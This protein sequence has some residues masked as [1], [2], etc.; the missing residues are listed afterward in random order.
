MSHTVLKPKAKEPVDS[1]T[2]IKDSANRFYYSMQD[3]IKK[4]KKS[5]RFVDDLD[6]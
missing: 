2:Y 4:K 1:W 5:K 3:V 6:I